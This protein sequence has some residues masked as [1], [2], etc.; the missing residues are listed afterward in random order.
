MAGGNAGVGVG[1][2]KQKEPPEWELER[3]LELAG[4]SAGLLCRRRDAEEPAVLWP[5]LLIF[6]KLALSLL[7]NCATPSHLLS[8]RSD[9]D[10]KKKQPPRARETNKERKLKRNIL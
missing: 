5:F 9:K 8:R 2:E 3:G 4:G 6:L 10:K 1:P 7:V